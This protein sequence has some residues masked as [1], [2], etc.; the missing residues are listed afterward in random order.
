[1]KKIILSALFIGGAATAVNAQANKDDGGNKNFRFN[2][3]PGVGYQFNDNWTVGVTG[4]FGTNRAKPKGAKDW[5]YTNEYSAGAF[6]RYTLPLSKIFLFYSQLDA[7]YIGASSG[8]TGTGVKPPSTNGFRASLTPAIAI[9]V[10]QGFA[11]NFG[12]GGVDF[13]TQ[14]VSG[15]NSS[16][17]SFNLTWG[18]QVNIGVSK[19]I[20]CGHKHR[21]GHMKMNHGSKVD[22]ED[23][24]DDKDEKSED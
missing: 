8:T 10:H 22:K 15:A 16:D 1:M 24:E 3:N 13:T 14:K 23:M 6:M 18:T 12:F 21:K 20:F 19:N 17:N 9:M 4:S 7:L 2:I 5:G 11:L